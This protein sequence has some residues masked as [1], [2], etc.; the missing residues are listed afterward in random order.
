[1]IAH[2]GGVSITLNRGKTYMRI[3]LPIAQLYH[4]HTD[5]RVPYNLYGNRQD[6][7]SYR[8]PSRSLS[9]GASEGQWG[10][11]GGCE[12]GFA[13][14]DTVTNTTVWS[15][16]YD[17]GL[18][19]YDTRTDHA[20]NVRVWPEAAYGWR[21]A[22]LKYR[23]NWTFPIAI[24]PHDHT[25]V[26]VGSQYVHLTTDGGA[27]WKVISPDLTRNDTTHQQSSGGVTTDNLMTFDGAT[28]FALAE[29]PVQAGVIWAGSNDGLVHV[30]RDGGGTWVNVTAGIPKLPPWGKIS[31]I[32]PSHF[33]PGTAYLSADLHELDDLDPYIYKTTDFGKT[34]KRISDALPRSPLSF[35]HVVREDPSRAGMLYAGTENGAYMTID[36]GAHWLPLQT[37]LPHAPVSWLTVQPHAR[38][39]VVATYGRGAWILEDISPLEQLEPATLA[40]KAFLFTP[41]PAYR[42]RSQQGVASAPNSAVEP[43]TVPYGADVTYYVSPSVADTSTPPDTVRRLRPAKVVILGSKGD[44]VRVLEGERR[45]GLNR[46]WW[47]LRSAPP[48]VPKLRTPPPG[49]AFV[50]VGPDGTRPL[51]TWDL[52]LSL[53]G[54]LAPP[55]TYTVQLT[56]ADTGRAGGGSA[57]TLTQPLRVLKD[58]NTAGSDSDVQAQARLALAIRGEQDS[59][60]RMINRLEWVRKQLR[61]L[62]GQLRGDSAVVRDS[63]AKRVAALADSLDARALGVEGALFDVHLTGA[64]EDAFRS[65]MQLYGRLAA[66]QSDVSE[67]GA[68]FAPTAQQLAVH[69]LFTQRLTEA[70]RRFGD[71]VENALPAFGAELRKA[72]LKD[73]ISAIDGGGAPSRP[74]P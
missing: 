69:E 20:R 63:N 64:R 31:N 73:V 23:W 59:V 71:L 60:A 24:S 67:S 50:R 36:D 9:G 11:G 18:E 27:S 55:G 46:V 61:D 47:D 48:T 54:P 15:G 49:K 12:S 43:D 62:V 37:N 41:R 57:V 53:R 74:G 28:L 56:L 7:T 34:W 68:D 16:C 22:D 10:H 30:T 44:T 39:L 51:V 29:S 25:R 66:L 1:M 70:A 13:I 38:D 19:V 8:M 14:P 26:Y 2:D 58:P 17:G 45:P 65:P 3:V 33:N 4:V 32:E 35:V 52:D 5:T 40:A 21:P 6:G 72:P 42:F